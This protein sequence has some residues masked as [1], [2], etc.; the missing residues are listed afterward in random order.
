MSIFRNT[1]PTTE[2][3]ET[4]RA[5]L[6]NLIPTIK[7]RLLEIEAEQAEALALG[8]TTDSLDQEM[9]TLQGRLRSIPKSL[10]LLWKELEALELEAIEVRA[11]RDRAIGEKIIS[12][13]EPDVLRIEKALAAYQS[14]VKNL[15]FPSVYPGDSIEA[16]LNQTISYKNP[17]PHFK[18]DFV[19]G[20]NFRRTNDIAKVRTRYAKPEPEFNA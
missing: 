16:V 10:D 19:G 8:K 5:E 9:L 3:I 12:D 7:A 13:L 20:I 11:A 18:G 2:Q 6:K 15:E 4:K 14:K 1:K 17:I